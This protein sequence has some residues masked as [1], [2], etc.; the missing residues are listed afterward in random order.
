MR[1]K[2]IFPIFL[3]ILP[4]SCN[5]QQAFDSDTH[6]LVAQ[7]L[8]DKSNPAYVS[9]SSHAEPS[10][11]GDIYI[12]GGETACKALSTLFLSRDAHDNVNGRLVEDGLPDFAGETVCMVIDDAA[13]PYWDFIQTKGRDRMREHFLRQTISSLDTLCN[14]SQYDLEGKGHRDE[15]KIIILADPYFL[16]WGKKDVDLLFAA[17]GCKVPVLQPSDLMFAKLLEDGPAP[18]NVGII[19]D[20]IFT[21]STIYTESL[22]SKA[23]GSDIKCFASAPTPGKSALFSFLDRYRENGG[24]TPLDAILIEDCS[25]DM[26]AF[27]RDITMSKDLNR[28]EYLTYGKLLSE[29][30]RLIESSDVVMEYCFAF[31]R[32]S[33][34]FTHK[35]AH[36]K[37]VSYRTCPH[38]DEDSHS[39]L[40]LQSDDV[41]D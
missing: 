31:L 15:A 20:S 4:L 16:S 39:F 9:L 6:P 17:T 25:V 35:I 38:P 19:C 32:T 11:Q 12:I 24:R 13:Y 33:N 21:R 30:F 29:G 41:Q 3:C 8:S 2:K 26:A 10:L 37:L 18:A 22:K 27:K 28:P 5:R 36:P 23:E 7:I 1:I 40:I 34:L 14:L